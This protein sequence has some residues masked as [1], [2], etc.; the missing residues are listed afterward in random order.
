MAKCI[1]TV[2]LACYRS[3]LQAQQSSKA[4]NLMAP[5]L[6][7]MNLQ[8]ATDLGTV[9]SIIIDLI[10]HCKEQ[11]SRIALTQALFHSCRQRSGTVD[12]K[13]RSAAATTLLLELLSDEEP[14]SNCISLLWEMFGDDKPLSEWRGL[15]TFLTLLVS[16]GLD[17]NA[18]AGRAAGGYSETCGLRL[19]R[20]LLQENG[21]CDC[22]GTSITKTG[23]SDCLSLRSSLKVKAGRAY[24][25]VNVLCDPPRQRPKISTAW[26]LVGWAT[27]LFLPRATRSRLR[28][29]LS[30]HCYAVCGNKQKK[31][32]KGSKEDYGT[33]IWNLAKGDVVGCCIDLDEGTI[34]FFH[35]GS[36]LGLAF[37]LDADVRRKGLYPFLSLGAN[38][39]ADINLGD[40]DF[41][42]PH[43]IPSGYCSVL[44]CC[45][46]DST[47]RG[48]QAWYF[49]DLQLDE[50]AK[51]RN[52]DKGPETAATYQALISHMNLNIELSAASQDGP[53]SK[54]S[55][56]SWFLCFSGRT[57]QASCSKNHQAP[58]ELFVLMSCRLRAPSNVRQAKELSGCAA[59]KQSAWASE[60]RIYSSASQT[61]RSK[62]LI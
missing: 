60:N 19:V 12:V 39:G 22:N 14:P 50:W 32:S 42:F 56:P 10:L 51:V 7:K 43:T 59:L 44:E 38:Q 45:A 27:S 5:F 30:E 28:R 4:Q 29:K 15:P 62:E 37:R 13:L 16:N 41:V 9:G 20:R 35:N 54:V 52:R 24:F 18:P 11:A 21:T 34:C 61:G 49:Y 1:T 2:G 8:K 57:L 6:R 46:E 40:R 53:N 58:D 55:N 3:I 25:E 31:Y 48:A 26:M 33:G 17:L 23:V 47:M 36:D